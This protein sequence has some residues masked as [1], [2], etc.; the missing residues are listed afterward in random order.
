MKEIA[1]RYLREFKCIA[2]ACRHSCCI[3]WEIDIDDETLE[4]YRRVDGEFGKRLAQNIADDGETACFRLSE[5]EK[6]PFLNEKGLCDIYT[7]LGEGALCQ[8]C[9]DHP[10][11]RNYF[12]DRTELG[13]GLCCEA[14]CALIL[15]QNGKWEFDTLWDDGEKEECE[16]IEDAILRLRQELFSLLQEK[17]PV[18]VLAEKMLIRPFAQKDWCAI[19]RSLEQLDPRWDAQL[20][21]LS[22]APEAV[23]HA[24]MPAFDGAF[25]NL[26]CYF[27]YRHLPSAANESALPSRVAFAY[28]AYRVIRALC[29]NTEN[30]TFDDLAELARLYSSE[31]E[32]S[33]DNTE[34]LFALLED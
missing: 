31:I 16:P 13:I 9:T 21:S 15:S 3:G 14:A 12:S 30:C 7:E 23:W 33:E 6:C 17:E 1:P 4:N 24:E 5:D 11:F 25:R 10:R 28:L 8:I 34:A 22:Q 26:L 20:A 29:A 27:L 2:G 32:Y 19:L 18:S